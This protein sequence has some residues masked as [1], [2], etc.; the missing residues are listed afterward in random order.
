M[1]GCMHVYVYALVL[2]VHFDCIL[3]SVQLHN[4]IIIV[5]YVIVAELWQTYCVTILVR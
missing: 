1:C 3:P 5:L 4:N 2:V